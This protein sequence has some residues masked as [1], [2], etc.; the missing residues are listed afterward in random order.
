MTTSCKDEDCLGVAE[1]LLG[2]GEVMTTSCKDEGCLGVAEREL[3][4]GGAVVPKLSVDDDG[5][6]LF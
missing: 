6:R 1:R 3:S 4:D 5:R 2:G